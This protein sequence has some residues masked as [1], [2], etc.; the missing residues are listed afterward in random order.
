MN[1]EDSD[2]T[3]T[4]EERRHNWVSQVR[5]ISKKL[6]NTAPTHREAAY[7]EQLEE[8]CEK[9]ASGNFQ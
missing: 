9:V 3:K 5:A 7:W 8:D 1:A 2:D 6:K 4:P